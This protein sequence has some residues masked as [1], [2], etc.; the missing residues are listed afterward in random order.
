MKSRFLI[1]I[2]FV[3][4]LMPITI[5]SLLGKEM[6]MTIYPPMAICFLLAII[7][8]QIEINKSKVPE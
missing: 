7:Y 2:L 1:F 5:Y 6:L 4:V 8:K 3:G